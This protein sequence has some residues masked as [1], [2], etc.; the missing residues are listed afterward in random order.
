MDE[1]VDVAGYVTLFDY[2][3]LLLNQVRSYRVLSMRGEGGELSEF[4]RVVCLS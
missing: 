4:Q 2:I 1:D 3:K